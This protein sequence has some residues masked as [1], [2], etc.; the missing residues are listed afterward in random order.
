MA[1]CNSEDFRKTLINLATYGT[2]TGKQIRRAVVAYQEFVHKNATQIAAV[3]Q[4]IK[5]IPSD[6][7]AIQ[8]ALSKRGW[9]V[10]GEMPAGD[11]R[12]LKTLIDASELDELDHTMAA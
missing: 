12:S 9:F 6:F 10:L 11:F 2:E 4:S 8:Q 7:L 5:E 1:K 3:V